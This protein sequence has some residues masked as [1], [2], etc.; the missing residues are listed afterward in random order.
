MKKFVEKA[1]VDKAISSVLARTNNDKIR[2][3]NRLKRLIWWKK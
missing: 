1:T 3:K 2:D